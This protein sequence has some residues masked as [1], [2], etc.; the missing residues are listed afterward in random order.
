MVIHDSRPESPEADLNGVSMRVDD[1]LDP[2]L[3][4]IV[5]SISSVPRPAPKDMRVFAWRWQKSTSPAARLPSAPQ[6]LPR[7][8]RSGSLQPHIPEKVID[9]RIRWVS[10]TEVDLCDQSI[11]ASIYIGR[12]HG[13]SIETVTRAVVILLGLCGVFEHE[14]L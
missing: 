14:P 10:I 11:D 5:C 2:L 9:D 6:H 1:D 8:R 7:R 12:S 4:G 3:L 13:L